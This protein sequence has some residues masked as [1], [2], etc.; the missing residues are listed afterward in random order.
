[1]QAGTRTD[2]TVQCTTCGAT[3]AARAK[4]CVVDGTSLQDGGASGP[5]STASIAIDRSALK[6]CSKCS[7]T[8][9]FYAQFCP[10]DATKL[11]AGSRQD[12]WAIAKPSL[13]YATSGPGSDFGSA[14][15]VLSAESDDMLIGKTFANKYRID[16][17]LGE[18]GMAKVYLATHL[19]LEK[20]VVIKLMHNNLSAKERETSYKRFA[21]EIKVTAKLT[22]PNLV[23]VFDDGEISSR[24]YLVMEFIKG[25]SLRS[26]IA[27]CGALDLKEAITIVSQACAGLHEA[28][29]QGIIHRD[30]KPENIMLREQSD[31]PDWVKIVDFGIAHLKQGGHK[32]TATGIAVGTVDYMSPEYLQDKP[33]D[34]RADIYAMGIMLFELITG[35]CPFEGESCEAVL[36]K[37]LFTRPMPP[38]SFRKD[39]QPGCQLDL[40]VERALEKEPDERFQTTM[41]LRKA[42]QAAM[43]NPGTLQGS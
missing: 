2:R 12:S 31:R 9:P 14:E 34:H 28:H 38:S 16:S 1:L 42:L 26:Y 40:I 10:I 32:L 5:S 24:P 8:Y 11:Q 17:L 6:T 35:Q 43:A 27:R 7:Q 15:S 18:G 25:D 41:E 33:I 20:L 13:G 22:H 4:V 3:Y 29:S 39:M 36:A 21:Q 23:S 30:L 37:H 19:S